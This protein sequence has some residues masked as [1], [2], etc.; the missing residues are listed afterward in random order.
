[1]GSRL[2]KFISQVLPTHSQYQSQDDEITILRQD[3]SHMY[4]TVSELVDRIAHDL[5]VQIHQRVMEQA[6]MDYPKRIVTPPRGGGGGGTGMEDDD[7][8]CG[9][10]N[11][12]GS[13]G[14]NVRRVR[15]SKGTIFHCNP[16]LVDHQHHHQEEVEE[17]VDEEEEEPISE[18]QW[19]PNSMLEQAKDLVV[20]S[21]SREMISATQSTSNYT[22][23][24]HD[25]SSPSHG[26]WSD[27]DPS[28][29]SIVVPLDTSFESITTASIT[30]TSG[31]SSMDSTLEEFASS[32]NHTTEDA[33][34][35]YPLQMQ[36]DV[37]SSSF[38]STTTPP[39]SNEEKDRVVQ[40]DAWL[41]FGADFSSEWETG[42]SNDWSNST[43][44][45]RQV[46]RKE[47]G[48]MEG[49]IV[50]NRIEEGIYND[51]PPSHKEAG[52]KMDSPELEFNKD[53]IGPIAMEREESIEDHPLG[54]VPLE[55]NDIGDESED[56]SVESN[57][58]NDS[59]DASEEYEDE[60][61]S[62]S[63]R[64]DSDES[65]SLD[66]LPFVQKIAIEN[67]HFRIDELREEED[68]D[69]DAA[70][71]W[72]QEDDFETEI[73]PES[74]VDL[75]SAVEEGL[76]NL[77]IVAVEKDTREKDEHS[78][79]TCSPDP[80]DA[81]ND[82]IIDNV[83]SRLSPI[84][85]AHEI[86]NNDVE[87]GNRFDSSRLV[88]HFEH[89]NESSYISDSDDETE[90][91][92][93]VKE[94]TEL[95]FSD[96]LSPCDSS[97]GDKTIVTAVTA[98]TEESTIVNDS[99]SESTGEVFEY[100]NNGSNVLGALR[101]KGYAPTFDSPD[102]SKGSQC[103]EIPSK[104]DFL[105]SKVKD[106]QEKKEKRK[107]TFSDI[108]DTKTELQEKNV[109][110]QHQDPSYPTQMIRRD[111]TSDGVISELEQGAKHERQR[112]TSPVEET[113]NSVEGDI[114]LNPK[115]R[116]E[117]KPSLNS[118]HVIERPTSSR[119]RYSKASRLR[120]IKNTAAWKRR[121]GASHLDKSEA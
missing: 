83:D 44:E 99:G 100:A 85:L 57:D 68:A 91:K 48:G 56:V 72:A 97:G 3:S 87:D 77:N 75:D 33:D 78:E 19:F 55:F 20:P 10:G 90:H 63:S 109:E 70:D 115:V 71:S 7:A 29:E 92:L 12:T 34:A 49:D 60:N 54:I 98:E 43:Q 102:R 47:M 73:D 18:S 23:D 96:D 94:M 8:L 11:G 118:E 30:H 2:L 101:R 110:Q 26:S 9:D 95:E 121:Y 35:S 61:S 36:R 24:W 104:L 28:C 64:S 16:D 114:S 45:E 42:W 13:G 93:F 81:D 108:K 111:T 88:Q 116:A 74:A 66:S 89:H 112:E 62:Y 76:S 21:S 38:A 119:T 25:A 113:F 82:E 106:L 50:R 103:T 59:N 14:E 22:L 80:S 17:E 46:M 32:L 86:N 37:K 31:S 1:M 40:S 27:W 107:V 4:E 105:E 5:D 58:S 117:S 6:G 69:S 65:E 84:L 15:F 39:S 79:R 53:S 51:V 41:D 52:P 120:K 67:Y